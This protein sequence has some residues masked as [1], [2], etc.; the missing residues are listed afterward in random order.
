MPTAIRV[1]HARHFTG[2]ASF[3][4]RKHDKHDDYIRIQLENINRQRARAAL[5]YISVIIS[6][7]RGSLK[8]NGKLLLQ[9]L[10]EETTEILKNICAPSAHN[11]MAQ[12]LLHISEG[13]DIY[14]NGPISNFSSSSN[15]VAATSKQRPEADVMLVSDPEEF[16]A[17]FVDHPLHL[18]RFLW[19]IVG[20]RLQ[21]SGRYNQVFLQHCCSCI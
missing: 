4:A 17:T 6:G 7:R 3:L 8:V 5:V 11:S 15:S 20:S 13:R 2:G 12:T 10:P 21:S 16:I 19:H 9:Y 18:K 14:V 1:L